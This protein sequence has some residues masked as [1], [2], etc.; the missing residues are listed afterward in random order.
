MQK[1]EEC[2]D[3]AN[4]AHTQLQAARD[5]LRQAEETI[6]PANWLRERESL[7]RA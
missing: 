6:F 4:A 1:F 2:R 7:R 3:K 5:Q